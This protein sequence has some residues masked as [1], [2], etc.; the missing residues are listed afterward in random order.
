[1]GGELGGSFGHLGVGN[2]LADG[3][4]Q[5]VGGEFGP[6]DGFGADA[7]GVDPTAPK[8]LIR[9]VGHDDGRGADAQGGGGGARAAVMDHGGYTGEEPAVGRGVQ[10]QDAL[11]QVGVPQAGPAGEQDGPHPAALHRLHHKLLLL[12]VQRKGRKYV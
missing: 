6:G 1:M 9:H 5:P 8:G 11:R 3:L 10:A 7:Q 12:P 4:G 2:G